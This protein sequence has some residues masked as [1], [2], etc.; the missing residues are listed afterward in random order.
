MT[1]ELLRFGTESF[2]ATAHL[3]ALAASTRVKQTST[4]H[5]G[6]DLL[7]LW[8]PGAPNRFEPMRQQLAAGGHVL[9]LDLAYWQRDVK[10][11][12]SIDAAHPQQW[13]LRHRWPLTRL[14]ADGVVLRRLWQ[15]SGS[16]IVAGIG[17][18]AGI[19]YGLQ[20]V[21]AWE[22]QMVD[23]ARARGFEVRYRPKGSGP[24]PFPDVPVTPPG[25]IDAVL[26][27]AAVV[28]TWHSNV[29]IDA[30][31]LGIPVICRD[32]AAAAVC[33]SGWVVPPVPLDEAETRQ[34][35][36]NLAWFQW[37]SEEAQALWRWLAELLA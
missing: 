23:A 35:L 20:T 7:V 28:I 5:G 36:G 12:V 30:L 25:P 11:R 31:R 32:G 16:A 19:Q 3:A 22:R 26:A 24:G 34:F 4:Y 8:G 27:G 37:R 9:A 13:V 6:S 17:P 2:R 15:P 1:I 18:K 33:P 10:F 21:R 29:A 14:V